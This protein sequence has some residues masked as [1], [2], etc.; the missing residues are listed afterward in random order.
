M[1][2][3][4][5][6]TTPMPSYKTGQPEEGGK[7]AHSVSC[8]QFPKPDARIVKWTLDLSKDPISTSKDS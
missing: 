1:W 7:M 4:Y 5:L 3:T 6:N 8:M 2:W